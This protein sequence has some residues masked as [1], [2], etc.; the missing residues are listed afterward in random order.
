VGSSK[1]T[2]SFAPSQINS[3]PFV[4]DAVVHAI[5]ISRDASQYAVPKAKELWSQAHS[6]INIGLEIIF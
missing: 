3:I 5:P 2:T 6:D 1:P 4:D